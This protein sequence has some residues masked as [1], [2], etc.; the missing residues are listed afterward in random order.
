[1]Q[2]ALTSRLHTRWSYKDGFSAVK[3]FGVQCPDSNLMKALSG[4]KKRP[5][6]L[7]GVALST[8]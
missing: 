8:P 7:C 3:V 2:V 5:F 1:M 6:P 4:L